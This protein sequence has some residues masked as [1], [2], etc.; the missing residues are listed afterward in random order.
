MPVSPKKWD[1]LREKMDAL[2]IFES[3]IEEQFIRSSGKGG[4]NVNK[5]S[6][7]VFIKHLPTGIVVKCQ[8]E[9]EQSLN[10]YF[11]RRILAEKIEAQV[12][13]KKSAAKQ[14]IWKLKKQKKR[15]SKK[16]KE[17]VLE[18]KHIQSKKKQ[19]RKIPME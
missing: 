9:R 3:D 17:K 12:L 6:T 11:A 4:Q 14:K 13:G 1:E 19:L 15:R 7:C 5:V 18:Q 2:K 10:R 8:Q 16:A